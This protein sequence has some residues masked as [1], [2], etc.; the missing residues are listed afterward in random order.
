MYFPLGDSADGVDASGLSLWADNRVLGTA[1]VVGRGFEDDI[2]DDAD[3]DAD[4][5]DDDGTG[6]TDFEIGGVAGCILPFP[7]L[8]L[9]TTSDQATLSEDS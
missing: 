8:R 2:D 3:D 9:A 4:D 1:E 7:P 6:V 5:A